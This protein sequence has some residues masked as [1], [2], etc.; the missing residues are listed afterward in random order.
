M[1]TI[2][3]LRMK[4]RLSQQRIAVYA[5]ISL[6]TYI[7]IEQGMGNPTLSTIIKLANYLS[8]NP[9]EIVTMLIKQ[10]DDLAHEE[11]NNIAK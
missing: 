11:V 6:K 3:S 1:E 5:D 2:K 10:K 7:D 4:K 8:I 9:E